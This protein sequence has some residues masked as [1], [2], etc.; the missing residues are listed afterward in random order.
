M[1]NNLA[2]NR[3]AVADNLA[4]PMDGTGWATRQLGASGIKAATRALVDDELPAED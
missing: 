4:T 1:R 3:E 2:R